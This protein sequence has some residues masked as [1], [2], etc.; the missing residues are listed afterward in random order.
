[1]ENPKKQKSQ[2][3][4]KAPKAIDLTIRLISET[5]RPDED[6]RY[7]FRASFPRQGVPDLSIRARTSK[8][9]RAVLEDFLYNEMED[10]DEIEA[11]D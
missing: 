2:K 9:A 5:P 4:P 7:T 11:D 3:T 8:A 10:G 1:M 6:G